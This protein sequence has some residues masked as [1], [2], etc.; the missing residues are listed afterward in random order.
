MSNYMYT[1]WVPSYSVIFHLQFKLYDIKVFK[2]ELK[3]R[4]FSHRCCISESTSNE[5]SLS[6]MSARITYS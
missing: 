6:C 1:E 3:Q 5:Y 2:L 4:L